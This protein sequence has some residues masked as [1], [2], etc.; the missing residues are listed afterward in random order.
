MVR[1]HAALKA[2]QYR[3]G[4]PALKRTGELVKQARR[5]HA[6]GLTLDDLASLITL[7]EEQADEPGA[8]LATWL[9]DDTWREEL[10]EKR[11]RAKEARVQA[12]AER[13]GDPYAAADPKLAGSVL[14][15]VLADVRDG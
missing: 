2:S 4:T 6:N 14:S 8:L 3:N 9:D 15:S 12:R 10:D 7:D 5:L 11:N 1:L 13:G